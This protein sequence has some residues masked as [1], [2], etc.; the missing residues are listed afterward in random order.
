MFLRTG[1]AEHLAAIHGVVRTQAEVWRQV[2]AH[3]RWT[4]A[5][6]VVVVLAA[7][8]IALSLDWSRALSP[9]ELA[10]FEAWV[11]DTHAAEVTTALQQAA[12]D[13]HVTVHEANAVIEVAKAAP[14]PPG[15]MDPVGWE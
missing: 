9:A 7:S 11:T 12:Q 15:L 2:P 1:L 5:G 4:M 6:T 13:Q 10:G 14:S 3:W 8:G